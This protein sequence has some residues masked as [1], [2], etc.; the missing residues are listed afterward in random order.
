MQRDS[1]VWNPLDQRNPRQVDYEGSG[2]YGDDEDGD[3][4]ISVVRLAILIDSPWAATSQ[5]FSTVSMQLKDDIKQFLSDINEFQADITM[6]K[7]NR[8][9][10]KD[11]T[12][13]LMDFSTKSDD[14]TLELVKSR[15]E[16][17]MKNSVKIGTYYLRPASENWWRPID[18]DSPSSPCSIT[19]LACVSGQCVP[20][21]SRCNGVE[22]CGDGSDE[23]QCS[24]D[25]IFSL[26]NQDDGRPEY[27]DQN[28]N[29]GQHECDDG[30]CVDN[31]L[32]C[33]G[34]VDCPSDDSDESNCVAEGIVPKPSPQPVGCRAD[35]QIVCP[36][37]N[38]RICEVQRC[39]GVENCPK[40]PESNVKSWDEEDCLPLPN[41]TFVPPVA[42]TTSP[43][44]PSKS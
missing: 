37:G 8:I 12:M 20:I 35:T 15:L 27:W 44:V 33:N 36:D 30:V 38:T 22:E 6:L 31:A 2:D 10:K 41:V 11:E 13:V 21:T 14:F 26:P 7:F 39:D 17:A 28:C 5:I 23:L 34:I 18:G 19:E 25:P 40:D 1:F 29:F 3:D 16:N 32:V 42:S 43:S 4:E 24:N 9:S